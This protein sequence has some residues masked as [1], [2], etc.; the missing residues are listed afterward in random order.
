MELLDR[1]TLIKMLAARM[2]ELR[3]QGSSDIRHLLAELERLPK[4][5]ELWFELGVAYN[6]AGLQYL[7]FAM[8]KA[9]ME[10]SESHPDEEPDEEDLHVDEASAAAIFEKAV[11]A[12]GRVL[13]LSPDYYGVQCQ[14]GIVYG[15]M[16]R[17]QEA[18]ECYFKAL[19]EDEEDFSAAYYLACTYRDMGDDEKA[20]QYFAL[21]RRLN[22]DDS[23]SDTRI[24]Q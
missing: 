12:F 7:D 23:L 3:Q 19:E 5:A 21:A 9:R 16:H 2:E 22:P 18:V 14:R 11:K 1:A 15:N 8:E 13:E 24:E 4:E 20:A 10:H 17:L 6:Q